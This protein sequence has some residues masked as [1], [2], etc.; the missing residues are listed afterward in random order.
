[1]KIIASD[2]DGTL[3]R[4]GGISEEDK[5]AIARFRQAGHRFGVVTGRDQALASCILGGQGFCPDF[6][7]SCTGAVIQDAD[8]R[9][10]Y[11]KRGEVGP[12]LA[13]LFSYAVACGAEQIVFSDGEEKHLLDLSV[14]PLVIPPLEA[15]T[16]ANIRFAAPEQASVFTEYAIKHHSDHISAHRNGR[17]VDMPPPHTSKVTG[18][19]EYARRFEAPEIYTVGDNVNDLSMIREFCGY[20]VSNAVD[21]VK[22]AAA[23]SCDRICD[24]IDRILQEE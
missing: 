12:F 10:L 2:Y 23:H 6:L 3:N 15:F 20:A 22:A 8:G 19:Y 11:K 18:I 4:R 13:D 24:M 17:D 21:E 5:L 9:V 7:I 1:M 14:A 16:Q